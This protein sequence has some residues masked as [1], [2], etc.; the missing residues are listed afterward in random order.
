M[1]PSFAGDRDKLF[2]VPTIPTQSNQCLPCFYYL[3]DMHIRTHSG[4][5]PKS[6]PGCYFF[7]WPQSE[8]KKIHLYMIHCKFTLNCNFSF[9]AFFI[10]FLILSCAFE[11]FMEFVH[12]K[13]P[14]IIIIFII[15]IIHLN[16]AKFSLCS[17][18]LLYQFAINTHCF[19]FLNYNK[20]YQDRYSLS[21]LACS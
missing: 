16:C 18:N 21:C 4:K 7:S 2:G 10:L 14:I 1:N 6:A 20:N 17:P 19:P 3:N 11:H 13:C 8:K 9:L 5:S 12:Y 15:I